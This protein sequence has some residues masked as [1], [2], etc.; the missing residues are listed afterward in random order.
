[1]KKMIYLAVL[2]TCIGLTACAKPVTEVKTGESESTQNPAVN[3]STSNPAKLSTDNKADI[4]ADIATIQNYSAAEEQQ[5]LALQTRMDEA[6]QK[7]DKAQLQQ[8]MGEF[9]AFVEK[10][11]TEL[12]KLPL[13]SSEV[14]LLRQKMIENSQIG[15]E[16][17]EA[18]LTSDMTQAPDPA[19]FQPLQEKVMK[20]QQ[21][22][23]A[24]DQEIQMKLQGGQAEAIPHVSAPQPAAAQ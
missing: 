15:L 4:Q 24:I 20:A 8:L 1:M 23:M 21:E 3:V 7:Q 22:L 2:S 18:L 17:S 6:M 10:N 13:K 11:N 12:L 14:S 9:K 19:K 5:A 16:I